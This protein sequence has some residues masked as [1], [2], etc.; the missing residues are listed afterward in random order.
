MHLVSIARS[1]MRKGKTSSWRRHRYAQGHPWLKIEVRH[2]KPW[3]HNRLRPKELTSTRTARI[4]PASDR[5]ATW[6]ASWHHRART[7]A[8]NTAWRVW[9]T[10]GEAGAWCGKAK[11]APRQAL[12]KCRL[13]NCSMVVRLT[14]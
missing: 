2:R 9:S 1:K 8:G 7:Q 10:D 12:G 5:A 14:V 11:Q 13:T 4:K 3:G 6:E